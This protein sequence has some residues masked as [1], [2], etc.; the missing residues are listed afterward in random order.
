MLRLTNSPALEEQADELARDL[1]TGTRLHIRCRH[2]AGR[3]RLLQAIARRLDD[4]VV[5]VVPRAADQCERVMLDLAARLDVSPA[6]DEALRGPEPISAGLDCLQNAL[7]ERRLVVEGWERLGRF[8]DDQ[9]GLA[10]AN[11]TEPVREW[12]CERAR[13]FVS[14]GGKPVQGASPRT[15]TWA[16]PPTRLSN[17]QDYTHGELWSW[18]E[19]VGSFD[20]AL[21]ILVLEGDPGRW[22]IDRILRGDLREQLVA[23]LPSEVRRLLQFAAIHARPLNLEVIEGLGLIG[24]VEVGDRLG[25]WHRFDQTILV[26]TQWVEWW[27]RLPDDRIRALHLEL[28]NVFARIVGPGEASGQRQGLA[29]LEAHRHFVHAQEFGRARTFARYGVGTLIEEA[30][31]LSLSREYERAAEIYDFIVD[32]GRRDAIPIETRV[33]AYAQHY[34]HFNRA[35]PDI[36]LEP[37]GETISGYERSVEL[38]PEN[39]L[40][41]SRLVRAYFYAGQWGRALAALAEARRRVPEHPEKNFTL[42]ART[43]E[44]L[45]RRDRLLEAMMVWDDYSP[46]NLRD[47]SVGQQLKAAVGKG[48]KTKELRIPSSAVRPATIVFNREL[49]FMVESTKGGHWIAICSELEVQERGETP[50]AALR[51]LV[52]RLRAEVKRLVKAFTHELDVDDRRRKQRLLAAIDIVTS[53]LIVAERETT[54]VYGKLHRDPDGA[55]WLVAADD[56]HYA[57]PTNLA[58]GAHIDDYMRLARVATGPGGVPQGPVETL[59][60][61]FRR[62]ADELWNAWKERMHGDK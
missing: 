11:W 6:V 2:E 20:L 32:A 30:R 27:Q 61:P 59:E 7:G 31:L 41:W 45:I 1:N 40:F 26:D 13:A 3:A 18:S 5:L 56:A 15:V 22:Q 23:L 60:E 42:I 8:G 33:Q 52:E 44:G 35:R 34:L 9:L 53:Q 57:V 38:W 54:W 28:A 36:T 21:A 24:A 58:Q 14:V 16:D 47:Q 39:A 29:V 51:N 55:L 17:A 12:L 43:V 10:F 37:L 4:G 49:Y 62:T 19:D 48:W 25:L 50:I 46:T